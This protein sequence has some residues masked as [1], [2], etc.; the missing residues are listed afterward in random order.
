MTA[1]TKTR[2]DKLKIAPALFFLN[3]LNIRKKNCCVCLVVVNHC[4][5]IIGLYV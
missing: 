4:N 1:R 2:K 5:I 3:E